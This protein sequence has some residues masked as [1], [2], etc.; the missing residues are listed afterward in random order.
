VQTARAGTGTGIGS[1]Y[2]NAFPR[3]YPMKPRLPLDS[4]GRGLLL[5]TFCSPTKKK[6]LAGEY[7]KQKAPKSPVPG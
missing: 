4:L 2:K 1:G 5:P 3:Y 7:E 6:G